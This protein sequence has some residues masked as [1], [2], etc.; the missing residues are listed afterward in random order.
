MPVFSAETPSAVAVSMHLH[1]RRVICEEWPLSPSGAS[2][3]ATE[4]ALLMYTVGGRQYTSDIHIHQKVA[5]FLC[6]SRF[7]WPLHETSR[8][9]ERPPVRIKWGLLH[10][11]F[12]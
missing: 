7:A 5:N 2:P 4:D 11:T 8:D 3:A 10:L 9:P 12:Y 6:G 1:L